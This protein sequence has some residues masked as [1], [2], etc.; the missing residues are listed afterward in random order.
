MNK[1]S[2]VLF[3]AR[4][5]SILCIFGKEVPKPTSIGSSFVRKKKE[6]EKDRFNIRAET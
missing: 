3:R 2:E 6:K 1:F 4:A 5:S